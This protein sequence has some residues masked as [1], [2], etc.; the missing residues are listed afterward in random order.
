MNSADVKTSVGKLKENA[1][2]NRFKNILPSKS[3][4]FYGIEG[5]V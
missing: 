3:L 2:K 1:K 5:R 4:L